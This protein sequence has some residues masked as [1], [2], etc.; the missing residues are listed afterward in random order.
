MVVPSQSGL[1]ELGDWSRICNAQSVGIAAGESELV[2]GSDTSSEAVVLAAR[3]EA[4]PSVTL[5]RWKAGEAPGR[6]APLAAYSLLKQSA[7]D[8]SG[9]AGRV[10]HC[11]HA[12]PSGD[13]ETHNT[14]LTMLVSSA[15]RLNDDL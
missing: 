7:T 10:C 6:A 13:Q 5:A 11:I 12:K 14:L 9:Q 2:T 4:I 1:V 15:S 3:S 8:R